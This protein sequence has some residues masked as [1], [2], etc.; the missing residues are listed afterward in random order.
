[1]LMQI[2]SRARSRPAGPGITVAAGMVLLV[3]AVVIAVCAPAFTLAGVLVAYTG[4]AL[5]VGG[6]YERKAQ[7]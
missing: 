4:G 1:M 2:R 3:A 5:F 7:S 6:A